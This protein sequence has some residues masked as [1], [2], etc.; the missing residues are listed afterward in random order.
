VRALLALLAAASLAAQAA[1]APPTPAAGQRSALAPRFP[2][3]HGGETHCAAC[4][5]AES[6]G[7]VR[8]IH[9]RTGFP[10]VGRHLQV[11]CR[12]CHTTG[13]SAKVPM[14]C[15]GC[16]RDVHEGEFGGRCGS[17]H[18]AT[19]W[20][21][22]FGPD[23]HRLTNFPLSGRHAFIPCEQCHGERRGLGFA[24]PASPCIAC[25]Q[26]DRIRAALVAVD[27]DAAGFG[28]N[29]R[30]CHNTWTFAGAGFPAHDVC[31][32]ITAGPHAGIRCLNCHT[33]LTGAKVT[34]ACN[35]GT[36]SCI[37]CHT[38]SKTAPQH[39]SVPGFDCKD[40][41]CYECHRFATAGLRTMLRRSP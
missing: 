5:S 40:R 36:V 35:T 31:F 39:A 32:Q 11:T 28:P 22:A 3:D 7:D 20:R 30:E 19:S 2:S 27:H 37:Q 33:Q 25:H 16:H 29:C 18:D 1:P 10:L 23:A 9:D 17:C 24:R 41:K 38:C 13:F 4:H 8:F 6:W 26:A 21:A 12:A 14:A 15:V 34:G